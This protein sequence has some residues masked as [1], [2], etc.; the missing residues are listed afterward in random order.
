MQALGRICAGLLAFT[1]FAGCGAAE[2]GALKTEETGTVES[3]VTDVDGLTV[4]GILNP[5]GYSVKA[6][7]A[8]QWKDS[9]H[10]LLIS[11]WIQLW[12]GTKWVDDPGTQMSARRKG[13]HVDTDIVVGPCDPYYIHKRMRVVCRGQVQTSS[14][15]WTDFEQ[16]LRE[17]YVNNCA[18][19][20]IK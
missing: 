12:N 1:C 20:G 7:C 10:N 16:T 5:D 14:G 4:I 19:G 6:I 9:N 15:G 3:A 8:A 17:G 2:E 11:G 18:Y 13:N